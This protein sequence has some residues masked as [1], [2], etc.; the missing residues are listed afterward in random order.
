MDAKKKKQEDKI[1]G[2]S[3]AETGPDGRA[4]YWV[5]IDKMA[6]C[7]PGMHMLYRTSS[8]GWIRGDRKACEVGMKWRGGMWFR[9]DVFN[10]E[11]ALKR[12][13]QS[14]VYGPG[15]RWFGRRTTETRVLRVLVLC[16]NTVSK[17]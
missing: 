7:S 11:Y 6:F 1:P 4:C 9:F 15:V 16:L 12:A 3:G 13:S 2:Q 14:T 10:G 17:S 5:S 8:E